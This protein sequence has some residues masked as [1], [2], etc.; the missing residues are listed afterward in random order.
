M[1]N[2][3]RAALVALLCGQLLTAAYAA[4][5]AKDASA[6]G[7]PP[8]EVI[9]EAQK[10]R[11]T[12][13][14]VELEKAQDNF[15]ARFNKVNTNPEYETHCEHKPLY[16]SHI[17]KHACTPRFV[18]AANEKLASWYVPSLQGSQYQPLKGDDPSTVI[19][20]KMPD[21][22]RKVLELG[23]KDPQL[24]KMGRDFEALKKHYETVRK[25][26]FKNHWFVWD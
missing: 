16:G 17:L 8:D 12:R 23:L 21:Y 25:A 24:A 7:D 9:V 13:L 10:E 15:F 3:K 2:R 11:L 4:S 6:T 19:R 14:Q 18:D 20:T 26:K 5:P 1:V 22:R